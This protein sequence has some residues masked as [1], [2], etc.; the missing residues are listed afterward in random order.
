[1]RYAIYSTSFLTRTLQN[2]MELKH[3]FANICKICSRL[4][5]WDSCKVFLTA[6]KLESCENSAICCV[7]LI[8]IFIQIVSILLRYWWEN[9]SRITFIYLFILQTQS[10]QRQSITCWDR[11]HLKLKIGIFNWVFVSLNHSWNIGE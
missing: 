9:A 10:F 2:N 7:F 8:E 1:M 11:I 6:I 3:I 5:K 4:K